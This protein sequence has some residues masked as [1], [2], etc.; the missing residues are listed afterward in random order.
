[1]NPHHY[2]VVVGISHYP[3]VSDL[4][5]PVL[6]A[7]AFHG[8]LVDPAGGQVPAEN[9]CMVTTPESGIPVADPYQARPI[10]REVDLA[11]RTI[12]KKVLSDIVDDP[13]RY[14]ATRLYLYV[15]G[16]GIM[17]RG[18]ETALLFAD[19]QDEWYE[20]LE[21]RSYLDWY[22]MCA[23]FREVV[24]FADCC[25]NWFQHVRPSTVMFTDCP[26]PG[27]QVFTLVGYAAGPG[28]PAYEHRE[29]NV[30][31]DERRGYFTKALIEGLRSAPV[32]PEYGVITSNT[33]ARFVKTAV[34]EATQNKRIPQQAEMSSDLSHPI[35]LGGA[36]AGIPVTIRFPPGWTTPVE[37]LHGEQRTPYD[38]ALGPWALSLSSGLYQVVLPGT[39]DGTPFAE[40]GCFRVVGGSCDIQL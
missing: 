40:K 10:K 12:N 33:L 20:N 24:V 3:G 11:L 17:P 4:S 39:Y 23:R 27:G 14:A 9:V 30:P 31:P 38:A 28:D 21:V 29:E 13:D 5:G 22:R 19:A 35:V 1:M 8:W 25:R 16:H 37:L 18:G 34:Q 32:D 2:G 26:R 36:P 15:A 7:R 6:D